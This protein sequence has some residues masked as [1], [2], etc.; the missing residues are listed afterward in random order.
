MC[1]VKRLGALHE[2]CMYFID[3]KPINTRWIRLGWF[4]DISKNLEYYRQ[5]TTNIKIKFVSL[6]ER[7]D[8]K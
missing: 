4:S 3:L 8:Q 5:F 2:K 6:N 1:Y 7:T